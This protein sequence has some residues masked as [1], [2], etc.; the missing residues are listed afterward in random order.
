MNEEKNIVVIIGNCQSSAI[1]KFLNKLP[2]FNDKYEISC[3]RT[4]QLG[5]ALGQSKKLLEEKEKLKNY[6]KINKE[7]IS[8]FIRQKTHGWFDDELNKE[9]F[10][11]STE[12]IEYPAC[13]L[14]YIWPLSAHGSANRYANN[15]YQFRYFPFSIMDR[16]VLDLKERNISEKEFLKLYMEIDV[17]KKYKVDRLKKFNEIKSKEIDKKSTFPIWDFINNNMSKLQMF[18]TENHPNGILFSYILDNIKSN[19]N[20]LQKIDNY[21]NAVLKERNSYGVNLLEA[22]VHPR[23]ASHF[24]LEWAKNRTFSFWGYMDLTFEEYLIKMYHLDADEEYHKALEIYKNN[25]PEAIRLMHEAIKNKPHISHY[26]NILHRWMG[27]EMSNN[28]FFKLAILARK[29][30]NIPEAYAL[31]ERALNI[32]P[33]NKRINDYYIA[34]KK[35]IDYFID[36]KY[37]I[38]K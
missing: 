15:K 30:N 21:D 28:T 16:E 25:M 20:L 7:K 8:I 13:L 29:G 10:K 22:P 32:M 6:V 37:N 38:I 26:K 1:A 12:I 4:F 35:H 23:I 24:N 9:D 34:Y 2:D 31:M 33:H 5:E 18:R 27:I 3:F 11:K 17:V 14:N 36:N 19:S